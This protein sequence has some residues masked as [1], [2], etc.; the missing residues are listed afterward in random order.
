M[1]MKKEKRWMMSFLFLS[2][3]TLIA[4]GLVMYMLDPLLH[5]GAEKGLLTYYEY[6]EMYSNPGI[7]K[8][9]EYDTVMV[10]TSMIENTDVQECNRLFGCNMVRLPY[11]GGT[12]YNM[13]TILDVCFSSGNRIDTVYWELDDF[14]LFGEYDQ[15]R[16]PLPMYLYRM[17]HLEDL[18]YLLNLDIL[19]HYGA[20][21]LL[22]TFRG[23]RQKAARE[24]ETFF[25]NFSKE[26]MMS[27]YNRPEQSKSV[28]P[29][30]YYIQKT[31]INLET[32]IIP[33]LKQ[34]PDTEFVFFMVPFSILYWD[35]EIRN[36]TL[37]A[38]LY[39]IEHALMRLMEYDQVKIYFFHDQWDIATNLDNY[40]D[41]THYGKW[42]NSYMTKMMAEDQC[43]ITK[44]NCNQVI[45]SMKSYLLQ[46]DYD[47][48]FK[49]KI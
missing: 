40:K 3:A 28:N 29:K 31:D 36:G 41:F 46:Y 17:D 35:S 10:G 22:G 11:S 26:A 6:S 4:F 16:Y 44:D 45:E 12:S 15:P 30:D 18:S 37:D 23:I 1:T 38:T 7:A 21:S 47:A 5:Y 8:H 19:Y 20:N 39:G 2:L 49:S 9:Y 13:K 43:R 27:Q 48:V 32:N 14:Q 34:N 25:G 33:L 42:I 24:G